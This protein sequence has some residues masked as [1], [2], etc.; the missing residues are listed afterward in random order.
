MED[1]TPLPLI[2]TELD[3]MDDF[4]TSGWVDSPRYADIFGTFS[5]RSPLASPACSALREISNSG[6]NPVIP[7][8]EIQEEEGAEMPFLSPNPAQNGIQTDD[9]RESINLNSLKDMSDCFSQ[10]NHL[11]L[12]KSIPVL[13]SKQ[14]IQPRIPIS[15]QERLTYALNRIK[16]SQACG[17]VLVQIWVPVKMGDR[18]FLSTF[19]QPFILNQNCNNLI[20]YRTVSAN[21]QFA[22]EKNS[23]DAAGL[24]GRVFVGRVPEW[25]PDVRCFSSHEYPRI[26]HAERCNVRGTIALPIFE[27]NSHLCLG[28]VELVSTAQKFNY[29]SDVESICNALQAVDLK[30]S[31]DCSI[32]LFKAKNDSYTAALPEILE[33]L[34]VV[35]EKH[36][37]PLAQTWIPCVQQGK[38][39]SRHSEEN[40][41]DCVSTIDGACY[42][43]DPSVLSFHEACSEHHLFRGQGVVGKAF[44]TN[45]PC[46][47]PDVTAF[48]KMEYP[49]SHH[50]KIFD[51]RAAVAIRLRSNHTGT[52]DFVLEFFLPISCREPEKQ[53]LM[54]DSL[55]S[56]IQQVCQSLRVVSTK[57][58]E[59]ENYMHVN[60]SI[61][62]YGSD[63][64]PVEVPID[65]FIETEPSCSTSI[66]EVDREEASYS[67]PSSMPLDINNESEESRFSGQRHQTEVV[68]CAGKF[69][70]LKQY[71]K[72]LADKVTDHKY[73]F[74]SEHTTS[75]F[76]K[77]TEKKRTKIEKTVSMQVLQQYFAGSLKDAAKSIGV[78][79]TTLK[80]ICRQHGITRWPSRKIKKV[81]HSIRKLQVVIDSVQGGEGT[82]HF[83][84]LYENLTE[85]SGVEKKS[86]ESNI[87]GQVDGLESLNA[88]QKRDFNCSP[89]I[90]ASNSASSSCSQGSS[91]SLG[92]SS[93]SRQ[94]AY[95]LQ[96]QIKQEA[97]MDESQFNRLKRPDSHVELTTS[98]QEPLKSLARAQRRMNIGEHPLSTNHPNLLKVKAIY[99]DEKVRFRLQPDWGLTD[100]KQEIARR[101]NI[102]DLHLITLKYLDD[103]SEWVLL[104]CDA[105]IEECVD[106][107]RSS[108]AHTV[109]VSVHSAANN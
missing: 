82:F 61:P 27:R 34:K 44:T 103:D 104:T 23:T 39:G 40:Y 73:N 91:S 87:L 37:L 66:I 9:K 15:L 102:S 67:S 68:I 95:P 16:E 29:H 51:L 105:D 56:T 43:N 2:L 30:I 62:S 99:G 83:S 42:V 86:S 4:L 45:Q 53:R 71:Q 65:G 6:S 24:P 41:R 84:P 108:G 107:Y 106:V 26:T 35:C 96:L 7:D 79:P 88:C 101:F 19:G 49:L 57:E 5:S 60:T 85:S 80:R 70:E 90:L 52:A 12:T 25:T 33:V 109:K 77:G 72:G 28:V 11:G 54:L 14:W 100:L 92:D 78:C 17:N 81:G 55:S 48:S 32:T 13:D 31:D 97:T 64:K 75:G 74:T 47:S 63:V 50:A 18:Y 46:F 1:T 76:R 8:T 98:V 93:C 21:Y 94:V 36:R 58:L 59:E 10:P 3:F 89:Y 38:R 20:Q 22:A 69:S